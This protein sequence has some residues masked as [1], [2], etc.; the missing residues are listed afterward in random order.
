MLRVY[1]NTY[2]VLKHIGILKI[3]IIYT[4]SDKTQANRLI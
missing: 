4:Y 3:L 1:E 2:V